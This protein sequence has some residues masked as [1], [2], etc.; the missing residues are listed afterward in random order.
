MIPVLNDKTYNLLKW[1]AQIGLPAVGALYFGLA[2]IWGLPNAE[3]VVGTITVVDVFLGVLLGL[4]AS[5]YQ[6]SEAKYDGDVNVEVGDDGRKILMLELNR[7][8]VDFDTKQ[9]LVFK[10]NQQ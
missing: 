6:R 7:S 10:V 3:A 2:Q 5:A 4:S 1:L 8:P 9:E